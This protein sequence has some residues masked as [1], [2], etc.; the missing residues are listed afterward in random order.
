MTRYLT[1]LQAADKL[2]FRTRE[3]FYK[4][5]ARHGIPYTRIGASLRFSD[6][7]LDAFMEMLSKRPSRKRAA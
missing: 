2:G 7:K 6:A 1:A 5:V 4:A 3:A